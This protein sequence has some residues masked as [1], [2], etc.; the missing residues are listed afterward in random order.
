[1]EPYAAQIL[2]WHWNKYYFQSERSI[3]HHALQGWHLFCNEAADEF[4]VNNLIL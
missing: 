4:I 1:M 3:E 2:M